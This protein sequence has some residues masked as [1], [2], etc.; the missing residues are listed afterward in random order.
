MPIKLILHDDNLEDLAVL[1]DLG[2]ESIKLIIDKI[3]KLSPPPLKP[4]DLHRA[5]KEIL[6]ERTTE[7]EI[8]FRP[9]MFLYNL[10]RKRNISVEELIDG[11][12]YSITLAK[13]RWDED[14]ISEWNKLKPLFQELFSLPEI[15]TVVKALDLAYDYTHLL[16]NIKILTDIRPVYN[17]E[18][19]EILGAVVSHTL[20]LYYDSSEGTISLSIALDEE[21]VEN[22]L[23]SCTR[24]LEKAKTAQ[25]FM[26][27]KG[28]IDTFLCGE[29][30]Y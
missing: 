27:E 24:A 29:E 10:R 30:V 13:N 18:A 20:R 11:L 5:L 28:D 9:L 14:K 2:A 19:T 4:L 12:S 16:R 15:W 23:D 22:L 1:R 21:D 6:P 26:R 8:I 3:K 17:E 25:R 7:I